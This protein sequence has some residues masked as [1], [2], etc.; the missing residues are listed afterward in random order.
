MEMTLFLVLNKLKSLH[1]FIDSYLFPSLYS[2]FCLPLEV[3]YIGL[4]IFVIPFFSVYHT[5][6]H[7]LISTSNLMDS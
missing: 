6:I 3:R 2:V 4:K 1:P 5:S 7:P